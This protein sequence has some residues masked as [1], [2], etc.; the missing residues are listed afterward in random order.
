MFTRRVIFN[1]NYAAT[2]GLAVVSPLPDGQWRIT[3]TL[4][5]ISSVPT[6]EQLQLILSERGPRTSWVELGP[7][8]VAGR[9]RIQPTVA[10]SLR[11]SRVLLAGDAAHTF[12]PATAQG[13]NTGIADAANLGW[14]L[15]TLLRGVGQDCLLDSYDIERRQA[16]LDA[17]KRTEQYSNGLSTSNLLVRGI[18]DTLGL[19]AGKVERLRLPMTEGLAGFDT[20]YEAGLLGP[21]HQVRGWGEVGERVEQLPAEL[22]GR[23]TFRLLSSDRSESAWLK[24]NSPVAGLWELK[25]AFLQLAQGAALVRPDNHI[26]WLGSKNSSPIQVSC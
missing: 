17:V 10:A 1:P 15:A 5:H 11:A 22:S 24:K 13:I 21:G 14:K 4:R 3:A 19:L 26:A 8:S 12:S 2:N 20:R 9:Y 18:R 7:P 23:G 16:A 25:S 6:R